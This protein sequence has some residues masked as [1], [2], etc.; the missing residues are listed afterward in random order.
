[1]GHGRRGRRAPADERTEHLRDGNLSKFRR[2]SVLVAA[3]VALR[4]DL[5]QEIV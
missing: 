5:L 4:L 1:M 2:S 3:P